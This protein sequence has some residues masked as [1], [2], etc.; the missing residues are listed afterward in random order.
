MNQH[1]KVFYENQAKSIINKLKARKM[2]GYYCDSMEDAGKKVLE[3]IGEPGKSVGYGG[4]MTIDDSDLKDKITAAG[5]HL[6]ERE[7]LNQTPEGEAECKSRLINADSFLMSTNAITLDGELVNIDGRGN[8]VAFLIYGPKQ[9]III[10]GMNKVVSNVEDGIRRVRNFATPPNT[11]R[12]NCD[13]PCAVT[14]QCADC[15]TN[16]IC[17]QIVTTRVSLVPGRIKVILVG[18]E[19][20]Y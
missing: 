3:L 10:A 15:L 13:T 5:H 14:G 18:E 8:R 9:V 1:K 19:L 20:G 11:V 6:I 12:L 7:K 2:E 17:C 16:S 4:S